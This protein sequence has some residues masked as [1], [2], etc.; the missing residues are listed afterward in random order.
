MRAGGSSRTSP[1]SPLSR[2]SFHS[3]FLLPLSRPPQLLH[4]RPD[5]RPVCGL[6]PS[7]R[8]RIARCFRHRWHPGG[9]QRRD[10]RQAQALRLRLLLPADRH[11]DDSFGQGA[12]VSISC[13]G[14]F[15]HVAPHIFYF[16]SRS[17]HFP[18]SRFLLLGQDVTLVSDCCGDN[19]GFAASPG[20]PWKAAVE[21]ASSARPGGQYR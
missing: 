14:S 2:V 16:L 7:S 6:L 15:A 13:F 11:E 1:H 21:T 8:V 12:G 19:C 10:S 20:R 4:Q 5:L 9:Q 3:L 17:C 18:S